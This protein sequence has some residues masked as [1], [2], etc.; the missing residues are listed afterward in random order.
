[1][2]DIYST[3]NRLTELS[4]LSHRILARLGHP[5]ARIL[6]IASRDQYM[7]LFGKILST[8]HFFS[9]GKL[10]SNPKLTFLL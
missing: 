3:D 9:K 5:L 1:M 7:V 6:A 4:Q 10:L 8:K 2:W